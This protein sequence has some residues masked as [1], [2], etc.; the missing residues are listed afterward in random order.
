VAADTGVWAC[1]RLRRPSLP[2]D[3]KSPPVN[4]DRSSRRSFIARA[5]AAAGGLAVGFGLPGA[6]LA[7]G[8]RKRTYK[9]A[10]DGPR[11]HCSS[12]QTASHSCE[13][14]RACQKHAKNKLFASREAA[15]K[16]HHRAHPGCRCGVKRGRKLSRDKWRALFRPDGKKHEVVDK[17]HRRVQQILSS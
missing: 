5:G 10:P 4:E 13:A 12:S 17:R 7:G 15:K 1:Q 2:V 3:W 6:A 16:H 9:L 11:Y 8:R 14:C